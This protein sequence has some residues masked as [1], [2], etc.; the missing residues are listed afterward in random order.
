MFYWLPSVNPFNLFPP[1]ASYLWFDGH[2]ATVGLSTN[3]EHFLELME[4]IFIM[5]KM[6]FYFFIFF[7]G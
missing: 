2:G 5:R 7:V 3:S 6:I 4:V 1:L